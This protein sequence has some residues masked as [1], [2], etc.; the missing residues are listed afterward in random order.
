LGE[1][2]ENMKTPVLK[3]ENREVT[4]KKVKTLRKDNLTPAAIFGY[5]G[6]F[7][8]QVDTKEL[9][10]VYSDAGHT[11]VVDIEVGDATHSVIINEVQINPVTRIPTH[12]SLREVRM[13][14]EIT[15]EIPFLLTGA[16]ESP[17]VKDQEQ[18]VIL[19]RNFI[20]LKGLP[21]KLPS[22]IT[23][24]VSGFNAGDTI[25]LKDIELPDGITLIQEGEEALEEVIVTT[26]SA[27]Q[28]EII[29]NI[30]EAIDENAAAVNADGTEVVEGAE[31]A[32]EA[33]AAEAKSE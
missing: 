10:R 22:E 33:P 32:T 2:K 26:T 6:N 29:E 14:V 25:T 19:S 7:N 5:K 16:D 8:V 9:I 12:V 30:Q 18:L 4:G 28:E 23:I 20:E 1:D 24:D 15:A 17:A 13:D 27:I 11:T 31:G 3:A 21:R